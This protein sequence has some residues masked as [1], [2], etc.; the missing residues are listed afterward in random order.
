M[1]ESVKKI[2]RKFFCKPRKQSI[3]ALFSMIARTVDI[4]HGMSGN[5]R[6]AGKRLLEVKKQ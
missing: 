1:Q 5:A 6:S 3:S 4:S 2:L